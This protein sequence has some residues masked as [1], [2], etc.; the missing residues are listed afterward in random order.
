MLVSGCDLISLKKVDED[1]L[2]RAR[3]L[4]KDVI[5]LKTE[6]KLKKTNKR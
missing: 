6:T 5:N 3:N 1:L 2:L 4:E